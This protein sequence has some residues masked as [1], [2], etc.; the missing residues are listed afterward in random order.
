MIIHKSE[1]QQ[2]RVFMVQAQMWGHGYIG[3]K[4]KGY[5]SFL[6]GDHE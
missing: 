6:F 5:I 1:M 4:T 3:R 2:K